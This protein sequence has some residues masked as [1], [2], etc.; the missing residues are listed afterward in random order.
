MSAFGIQLGAQFVEELLKTADV[1]PVEGLRNNARFE[2]GRRQ[3][4]TQSGRSDET[5]A[6]ANDDNYFT[7]LKS[8][9]DQYQPPQTAKENI[10]RVVAVPR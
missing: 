9:Y 8:L 3:L 6:L 10:P 5:D 7:G 2:L 1:H 4:L